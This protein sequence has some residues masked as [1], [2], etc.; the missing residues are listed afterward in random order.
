VATL[1]REGRLDLALTDDVVVDYAVLRVVWEPLTPPPSG[2]KVPVVIAP[3]PAG[4]GDVTMSFSLNRR[5]LAT[6][7]VFDVSGRRVATPASGVVMGPGPL[8]VVWNGRTDA[9]T[10]TPPGTYFVRLSTE[11]GDGTAKLLRLR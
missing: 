11:E 4:G 1:E 8:R 5:A 10:R 7:E 2:G 9:G 6:I 3:N